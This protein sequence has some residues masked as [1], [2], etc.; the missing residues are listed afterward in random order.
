MPP[1]ARRA[2][3]ALDLRNRPAGL[4][5][6]AEVRG[7]YLRV[8]E[9]GAR[10]FLVRYMIAGRRRDMWLGSTTEIT[11]A[12]AR[13]QAR[14]ARKLIKMKVDPIDQRDK[15]RAENLRLQA[16]AEWTFRKAAQTVH[17]ERAE[18][19]RN[20]KHGQQWINTLA[21]YA[22]PKIGDRPV[23]EISVADVKSVLLP[24]WTKKEETARRV[25]Q[26]IDAV[27][28]WAVAQGYATRNPVAD[29]VVILPRQSDKVEHHAAIP[30]AEMAAF[31]KRLPASTSGDAAKWAL[32]FLILT[33]ARSGEVRGAIWPEIDVPA[34]VWTIPGE[35]TKSGRPHRVP[36]SSR[37]IEILE[38]AAGA[39]G[40]DG[41]VFPGAK[42]GAPLSDMALT[43]VMR[44][45][46]IAAVPHGFR[47]SFRDWCAENGVSGELAERALAHVVKDQTE[48]AYHR[49]DQLEQRRPVMQAWSNFLNV[50]PASNVTPLR[51]KEQR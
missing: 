38:S 41:F 29:T 48:A 50:Q 46:E 14:E 35:R 26:R 31:M 21:T 10:G 27:M 34:K 7:L 9:T 22:F 17:A 11:L 5:S 4:H 33:A 32:E 37:A 49:T 8:A 6:D 1:Q 20:A 24:I 45:L 16:L 47:S 18:T 42:V 25:S 23:G 2:L 12:E 28:S 39:F 3:T 44:R 30:L 40:N 36:L 51:A 15:R 13:E 19:W 43:M